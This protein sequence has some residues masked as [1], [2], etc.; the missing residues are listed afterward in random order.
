MAKINQAFLLL[1]DKTT[2]AVIRSYQD[3]YKATQEMGDSFVLYHQK[4]SRLPD[5]L[6]SVNHFAFTDSVITRNNYLPIGFNLIPGNNHFPVLSFFLQHPTYDYYWCIEEDVKF[7]GSWTYF[8]KFFSLVSKDFITSHIR[9]P[10]EEPD[11]YW[12]NT[13]AHPYTIIPLEKRLRS[14]NPIYRISRAALEL[15]HKALISHWCGHHEVLL[16]TLLK[17]SGFDIMDFGGTGKFVQSGFENKF[18]M[19]STPSKEGV[20]SDGTMRWRPV[21]NTVGELKDK[22]YHPIKG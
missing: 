2:D 18:Y 17:Q 5:E 3:I 20:L 11:W 8:F 15:I 19:A 6:K 10:E 22:L 13:L 4:E 14:F 16:A 1:C 12:W 7:N 9:T 21:F